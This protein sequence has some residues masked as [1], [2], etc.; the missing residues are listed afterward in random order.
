MKSVLVSLKYMLLAMTIGLVAIGQASATSCSDS[1]LSLVS[2]SSVGAGGSPDCAIDP[3]LPGLTLYTSSPI[4]LVNTSGNAATWNVAYSGP[5]PASTYLSYDVIF[6]G[7]SG[8]NFVWGID[9]GPEGGTL[10]AVAGGFYT[11]TSSSKEFTG[12]TGFFP[13]YPGTYT[14]EVTANSPHPLN[15]SIPGLS[16]IDIPDPTPTVPEPASVATLA[17]GLAAG[18]LFLRKRSV[19]R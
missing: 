13:I 3:T 2:V 6:N 8:Q 16:S 11:F 12:T 5:G 17:I 14:V 10:S 7:T 18:L 4:G 9:V 1:V 19:K 15:V